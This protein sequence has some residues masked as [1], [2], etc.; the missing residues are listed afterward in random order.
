MLK[1]D[2]RFFEIKQKEVFFSHPHQLSFLV[3]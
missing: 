2:V 1:K 3:R